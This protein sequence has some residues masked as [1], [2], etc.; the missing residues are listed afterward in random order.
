MVLPRALFFTLLNFLIL[1][2]ANQGCD[3]RRP[4]KPKSTESSFGFSS[5][6]QTI[7]K[8]ERQLEQDLVSRYRLLHQASCDDDFCLSSRSH[9]FIMHHGGLARAAARRFQRGRENWTTLLDIPKTP[10]F[11]LSLALLIS[12]EQLDE[13][14]RKRIWYVF[15]AGYKVLPV[16]RFTRRVQ[17]LQLPILEHSLL[18]AIKMSA[19]CDVFPLH[20]DKGS[21]SF[22]RSNAINRHTD[23]T[24]RSAK[25]LLR[26][27]NST[28]AEIEVS[29]KS[30]RTFTRNTLLIKTSTFRRFLQ[31]ARLAINTARRSPST[32][33]VLET[34]ARYSSA[35][36]QSS[37]LAFNQTCYLQHPFV[38]ERLSA[39]F[40]RWAGARLCFRFSGSS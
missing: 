37:L 27:M 9:L 19:L 2:S 13:L 30:L 39:E 33:S 3:A 12:D 32:L 20:E 17:M 10:F 36:L 6:L 16:H 31:W 35:T 21:S 15:I 28:A 25:E 23:N 24:W 29:A 34:D 1:F 11:E 26:R 5:Q 8:D 4:S 22:L 18:Y 38:M 40:M 14:E 7:A